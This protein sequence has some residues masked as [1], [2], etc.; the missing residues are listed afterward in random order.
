MNNLDDYIKKLE[1]KLVENKNKEKSPCKGHLRLRERN[2]IEK[3]LEF[4]L[5]RTHK[6]HKSRSKAAKNPSKGKKK[7]KRVRSGTKFTMKDVLLR[8]SHPDGYGKNDSTPRNL[9]QNKLS[10]AG[11]S[12]D[13][14]TTKSKSSKIDYLHPHSQFKYKEEDYKDYY[15]KKL[16]KKV[17]RN[18]KHLGNETASNW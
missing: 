17:S 12:P 8:I 15:D 9:K 18:K 11:I 4:K 13:N 5:K 6:L 2:S 1:N 7:M 3:P 14:L 16:N 10:F